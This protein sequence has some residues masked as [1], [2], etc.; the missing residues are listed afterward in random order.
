MQTAALAT[1]L[2]RGRYWWRRGE[3]YHDEGGQSLGL[4]T[5]VLRGGGWLGVQV[6]K[7][8]K[9]VMLHL[10]A[11]A[12][13]YACSACFCSPPHR[14]RFDRRS[15]T[16]PHE[17]KGDRHTAIDGESQTL[18]IFQWQLYSNGFAAEPYLKLWFGFTSLF[19]PS[20]QMYVLHHP[21]LLGH[22]THDVPVRSYDSYSSGPI[23]T[24]DEGS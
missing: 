16:Y 3:R 18:R 7:D 5:L 24:A 1:L 13:G 12:N 4:L 8:L 11:A 9:Y 15:V 19:V 23:P 14:L 20:D 2:T 22:K 6:V 17:E 10:V 21:I